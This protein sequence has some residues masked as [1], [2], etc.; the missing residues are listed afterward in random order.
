MEERILNL[1][2]RDIPVEVPIIAPRQPHAPEIDNNN[3]QLNQDGHEQN[4]ENI[5]EPQMA[6]A[7]AQ[8]HA[9]NIPL[10]AQAGDHN[11][12]VPNAP[13]APAEPAQPAP[14]LAAIRPMRPNSF[15]GSISQAAAWLRNIRR[16][17]IA[18]EL[19]NGQKAIA[20]PLYLTGPAEFWYTNLPVATKQNYDALV[21]AFEQQYVNAPHLTML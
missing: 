17:F 18:T 16:Y 14:H 5:A 6:A 15:D 13:P 4:I 12:A 11:P 20:F 3:I 9:D 7:N 10:D 8:G 19:P 21:E 1:R 2:G